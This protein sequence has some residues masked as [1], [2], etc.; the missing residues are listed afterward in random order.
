[1]TLQAPKRGALLDALEATGGDRLRAATLRGG[2]TAI[3]SKI[4]QLRLQGT[5]TIPPPA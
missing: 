2:N 5:L 1:V 3:Y 4:K